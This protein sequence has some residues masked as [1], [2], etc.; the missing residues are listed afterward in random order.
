MGDRDID[1]KRNPSTPAEGSRTQQVDPGRAVVSQRI[2]DAEQR[3]RGL[4]QV[5]TRQ[6][7][8]LRRW[9]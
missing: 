4:R 7:N 6:G 2:E 9:K 1:W 3:A 8:P 5:P